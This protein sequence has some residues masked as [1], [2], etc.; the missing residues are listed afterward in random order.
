VDFKKW[1]EVAAIAEPPAP[2]KIPDV[3]DHGGGGNE[4]WESKFG[5]RF[6]QWAGLGGL[7]FKAIMAQITRALEDNLVLRKGTDFGDYLKNG[8]GFR[9]V[10]SGGFADVALE[11]KNVM[12]L[13]QKNIFQVLR[14]KC[15]LWQAL[16]LSVDQGMNLL[17]NQSFQHWLLENVLMAV[18]G[19]PMFI[20]DRNPID[21]QADFL[22]QDFFNKNKYLVKELAERIKKERPKAS[23]AFDSI[24]GSYRIKWPDV[25]L[26][27]YYHLK[28]SEEMFGA[29][30][31]LFDPILGKDQE[32]Q[33]GWMDIL[34]GNKGGN[35]GRVDFRIKDNYLMPIGGY[36]K[37]I[38]HFSY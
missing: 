16:D 23:L 12:F 9:V 22:I 30:N 18:F 33:V 26:V 19:N 4:D 35:L 36:I 34:D 37:K 1:L 3:D 2:P 32:N 27:G 29:A 8:T 11:A 5:Q 14:S 28:A 15:D 17:L 25:Y 21:N 24:H 7:C 10:P 38:R 31:Y 20:G 6:H 13:T